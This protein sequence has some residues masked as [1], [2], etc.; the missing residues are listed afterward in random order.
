MKT[1]RVG[2]ARVAGSATG[3]IALLVQTQSTIDALPQKAV[4]RGFQP[5]SPDAQ[6]GTDENSNS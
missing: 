4:L 6:K 1:R 5:S 2:E 3:T